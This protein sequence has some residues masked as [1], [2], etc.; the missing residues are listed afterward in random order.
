MRYKKPKGWKNTEERD[1][2]DT[3]KSTPHFTRIPKEEN[4]EEV[5]FEEMMAQ[6]FLKLI[7]SLLSIWLS[8]HYR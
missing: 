1:I 3:M 4:K 8:F 5:T 2:A 7:R 6:D